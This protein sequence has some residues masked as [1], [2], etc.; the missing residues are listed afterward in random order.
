MVASRETTSNC[1]ILSYDE[2]S[3]ES[4]MLPIVLRRQ[5][6]VNRFHCIGNSQ[7]CRCAIDET[8]VTEARYR[9][10]VQSAFITA[11]LPFVSRRARAQRQRRINEKA[12]AG[13]G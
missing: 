1:L 8:K 7:E 4:C 3:G 13:F 10:D 2:D 9:T 5:T 11:I 6:T 12:K